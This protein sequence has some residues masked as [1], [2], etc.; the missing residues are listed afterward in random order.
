MQLSVVLAR[1]TEIAKLHL[2]SGNKGLA[3]LALKKKK[4][5]ESLLESTANQLL[6]LEHLVWMAL[7]GGGLE[8]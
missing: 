6:N 5:Q 2:A 4:Y 3:L 7:P 8:C 1:E